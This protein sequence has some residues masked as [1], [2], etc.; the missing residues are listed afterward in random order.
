MLNIS[1]DASR[2]I[3]PEASQELLMFIY[4][5]VV[6][7]LLVTGNPDTNNIGGKTDAR[8]I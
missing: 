1:R 6:V 4:I 3:A 5:V 8:G 7:L 2:V